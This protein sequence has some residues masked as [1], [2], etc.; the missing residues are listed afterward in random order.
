[1]KNMR[2]MVHLI[3]NKASSEPES[4]SSRSDESESDRVERH[5]H[6]T[7]AAMAIS[8]SQRRLAT[9]D[10]R[11][12][13]GPNSRRHYLG[14]D[15]ETH[16]V[17]IPPFKLSRMMKQ[18]EDKRSVEYQR[19]TW[20]A[21]RKSING[22]VNKLNATNIKRVNTRFPEVGQILLGR[23]V[24]QFRRA[25]DIKDK[26]GIQFQ[27]AFDRKEKLR[28][29]AAAKFIAHLVNQQVAHEIIAL[30]LLTFLLD[31]PTDFKVEVSVVFVTECGSMLWDLSP[32]GL[33][34]MFERF[35]GI[36]YQGDIER[37]VLYLIENLFAKLR[38]KFQGHPA[39]LPELDLVEQED[40]LT[41]EISLL[42]E[43]DPQT[44][45]DLFQPDPDYLE[46]EKHYE[47]LKKTILG[48]ESEDEEASIYDAV[49]AVDAVS[50]S[51]D[52]EEEEEED[53]Q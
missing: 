22:P 7:M 16:G 47:E 43:I 20:D 9:E 19:L 42:D 48:D 5:L 36:L 24:L 41:H 28:L 29:L 4:G 51:E 40:K 33:Y 1:M 17:Y 27:R 46:S 13:S 3:R 35:R 38:A 53:E 11:K 44:S 31:N 2:V 15:D 26:P 50:D 30:E 39:V 23:L 52:D 12:N 14:H 32:K 6:Q 49:D 45:L 34:F 8:M 10:G 21:L 25:F 18:V 37:R